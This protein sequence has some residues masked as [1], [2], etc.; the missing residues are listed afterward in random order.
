L[1]VL[2]FAPGCQNTSLLFV[3]LYDKIAT[4]GAHFLLTSSNV[5][6]HVVESSFD[7]QGRGR[8]LVSLCTYFLLVPL[9][10]LLLINNHIVRNNTSDMLWYM[11]RLLYMHLGASVVLIGKKTKWNLMV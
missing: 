9:H 5:V 10:L 6:R 1:I 2:E 4:Q 3:W 7:R 8:Q 11:F